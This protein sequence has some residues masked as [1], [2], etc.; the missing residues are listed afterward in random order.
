MKKTIAISILT[1]LSGIAVASAQPDDANGDRECGG[2]ASAHHFEKLDTNGDKVVTRDELLS[3]VTKHFDLADANK[4][5]SVTP[6]E[7]Q[8]AHEKFAAERFM[9]NDKNKDGALSSDELPPQ[10]AKML[11]KLD[12][13]K[14]G[15]LTKEEFSAMQAKLAERGAKRHARGDKVETRADLVAHVSERFTKLDTNQ[16]GKLTAEELQKGHH[17]PHG[18][19]GR[20]A[21]PDGEG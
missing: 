9:Q 20:A 15:K 6:A 12:V 14:D 2:G 7:R 3:G 18:H 21:L 10:R 16:D 8:A 19:H 5:G 11:E 4:D 13:N 17:G 1:A